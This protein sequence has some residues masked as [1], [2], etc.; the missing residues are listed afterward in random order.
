MQKRSLY[1]LL[2]TLMIAGLYSCAKK[3]NTINNGQVIAT[4]YALFF[5][6]TAGA[7]YSSNDG[8]TIARTAFAADGYPG[9]AIATSNNN[10]LVVK[11]SLYVNVNNSINFNLGNNT[12]SQFL[13]LCANGEVRGLD[14]TMI[15]D[16]P[17]W[18]HVY[19]ASSDPSGQNYF[20]IA[21]SSL[22]GIVNSWFPEDYY[23]T[24]NIVPSHFRVNSFTVLKNG[25]LIA[26]DTNN[27]I[28]YRTNIAS[29]W[30]ESAP[31]VSPLPA[32]GYFSIGHLN[33][34]LIAIDT[35]GYN[36]AYYSNDMGVNW[37]AYSGLPVGR[38]LLAISSPFEQ[39]CFV[40]TDSA[41]L[42]VLNPGTNVFQQANA[43]LSST[44]VI[45]GISFKENVFK[46]GT[47]QQ[48][49]YLATNKGIFQSSDMGNNWVKTIPGNFVTI[50]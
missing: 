9:R 37:Y 16:V 45:N 1:F 24:I 43:G 49:L 18:N 3:S 47:I 34:Q 40:G 42:Y 41:G 39:L 19:V 28:F 13:H 11:P 44:M 27:N 48:Y 31:A 5:T 33:N 21:W 50:Y 46:N 2:L 26:H 14:Q 38:P 17:A 7:V 35:K 10:L 8:K 12:L 15:C 22:D 4:P 36:G 30:E 32:T 23:D 6:D 29:R 20:G 25:T